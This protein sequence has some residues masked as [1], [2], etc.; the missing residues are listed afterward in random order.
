MPSRQYK[1]L[2]FRKIHEVREPMSILEDHRIFV[3]FFIRTAFLFPALHLVKRGN[4]GPS[5]KHEIL[6]QP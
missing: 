2:Q 4:L 5:T 3:T 6:W 1:L